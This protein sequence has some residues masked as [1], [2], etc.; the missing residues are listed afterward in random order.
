MGSAAGGKS[1][2]PDKSNLP[3]GES[4]S[5]LKIKSIT[6]SLVPS[7]AL[8]RIASSTSSDV[9]RRIKAP[10][11]MPC[12]SVRRSIRA[13]LFILDFVFN[14]IPL[15]DCTDPTSGAC[16]AK[17]SRRSAFNDLGISLELSGASVF[18]T[19]K[20]GVVTSTTADWIRDAWL[21]QAL[22]AHRKIIRRMAKRRQI[23]MDLMAL[24]T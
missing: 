11:V 21:K 6:S 22:H 18:L 19:F 20:A 24:T 17:T 12:N 23:T 15:L 4:S 8:S 13:L 3:K 9:S 10:F 7:A 16:I 2:I 14:G 5:T 1:S